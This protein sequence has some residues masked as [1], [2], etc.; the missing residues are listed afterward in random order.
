VVVHEAA[1]TEVDDFD[2]A[3]GVGLN[4]NIL[5]LQI[6]MDQVQVVDEV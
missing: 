6:T 3:L 4:Q 5:W 1:G 2:L